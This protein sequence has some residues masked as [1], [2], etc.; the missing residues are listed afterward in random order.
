MRAIGDRVEQLDRQIE[1]SLQQVE[2]LWQCTSQLPRLQQHILL[3]LLNQ[4]SQTLQTARF[5]SEE[6]Q[7]AKEELIATRVSVESQHP[8]FEDGSDLAAKGYLV[9]DLQAA[10]LEVNE[11]AVRLLKME[12]DRWLGKSLL[13]WVPKSVRPHVRSQLYQLRQ[14]QEIRGWEVPIQRGQEGVFRVT[15]SVMLM[16]DFQDRAIGLRWM[17]EE[18]SHD[19]PNSIESEREDATSMFCDCQYLGNP[20]E[21]TP[22]E[23]S[24]LRAQLQ[25][26][27]V[28]RQQLEL[29]LGQKTQR[30]RVLQTLQAAICRGVALPEMFN[31]TVT[32]VQQLVESD[33]AVIYQIDADEKG[34]VVAEA[35]SPDYPSILGTTLRASWLKKEK[36]PYSAKHTC[37]RNDIQAPSL[38]ADFLK[39]VE[40]QQIKACLSVPIRQ[41][42]RAWG[43]L[44]VHQCSSQRNWQ[45]Q[46]VD[47]LTAVAMQQ[48]IAIQQA[49]LSQ[50][51]QA[52]NLALEGQIG[53]RTEQLQQALD[54]EAMLKRI[55]DKVRDS[56]DESQILQTAVQELVLGLGLK[57]CDTALYNTNHTTAIIS[58]EYTPDMPA[59]KGHVVR[60]SD[61]A[62]GY[63]QL[64]DGQ[65]FQF[66]ELV[67][68]L[69]GP[70]AILSCPIMDNE[71]AIG[72]MWLFK[73]QQEAFNDLEIRLVQQVANQCAIALRQARFYQEAQIQVT[74][75]ERLN[76]IKDEFL[77][78]VSHELRTPVSNMKMAIQML[79]LTLNREQ[80]LLEELEKP[81][82]QQSKVARYFQI[83]QNEC[84]RE[85]S[86]IND[87]LD[88]QRLDLGAQPLVLV[89]IHL[90]QWLPQIVAPF[91]ERAQKRQQTLH[92]DVSPDLPALICDRASLE[93]ILTELL[94]NACKYT[95][96]GEHIY[97]AAEA[98]NGMIQVH[99]ANTG[100][101]IPAS[102]Q[103]RIFEKFY[104]IPSAD[105]WKQGGTGLGLALVHKLIHYLGGK[106][107]VKSGNNQTRF[108]V[109]L[110]IHGTNE[111]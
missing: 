92:I 84:E 75:L 63:H 13:D 41:G 20:T 76:R 108:T 12:R 19:N 1:Y 6:M 94:N 33:R 66:C 14:G 101:E 97:M 58:Y 72:D 4:L 37:I 51:V 109:T 81:Q 29:E 70:L 49:E 86:L 22:A 106:I 100:V 34:V 32:E 77:S 18:M 104:R 64:I 55:T 27:L 110:P 71:G 60:M 68:S 96:P 40:R 59:A 15:F 46:D 105:P 53:D 89:A 111:M 5:V 57:G 93:R 10:I 2:E 83:L 30:E 62:E 95:P 36:L 82:A 16:R 85:I 99:V 17:I 107:Q 3:A 26:A 47:F 69:R 88:L 103:P 9:T 73:Q 44:V 38:P 24:R 31:L 7:V 23:L 65:Y 87:V 25:E 54:F 50:Q 79:A 43:L 52:L 56:L 39:W 61:F 42:D 90:Q 35:V 67:P 102:E 28:E 48:A 11:A 78:T 80:G 91:Q 21:E 45:P 8:H 98:Q 74:A